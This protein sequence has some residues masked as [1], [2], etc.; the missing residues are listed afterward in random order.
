[1]LYIICYGNDAIANLVREENAM[2]VENSLILYKLAPKDRPVNPD[3][4]WLGK[5]KRYC[6]RHEGEHYESPI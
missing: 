2:F 6:G 1:M 5:I 3:K 4:L